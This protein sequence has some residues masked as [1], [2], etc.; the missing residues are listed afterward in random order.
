M[1]EAQYTLAEM[2]LLGQGV[3]QDCAEA[4]RWY[5]KA[6]AQGHAGAQCGLGEM[7]ADGLCVPQDRPV[8]KEWFRK[9]CGGSQH[10]CDAYRQLN[11]A[12][13]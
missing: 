11:D 7:F 4:R 1:A 12:G 3:P 2:H 10:G 8:A 13:F 9:A 5:E 6:T